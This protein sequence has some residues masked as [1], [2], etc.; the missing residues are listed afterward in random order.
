MRISFNSNSLM[1]H[2][3]MSVHFNSYSLKKQIALFL[4]RKS[5]LQK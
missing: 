1:K 3:T 5:M 4:Y 2:K